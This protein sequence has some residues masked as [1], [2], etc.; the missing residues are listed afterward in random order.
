MMVRLIKLVAC[1]AL[2]VGAQAA[3]APQCQ[4]QSFGFSIASG[5]GKHH[6]HGHHHHCAP[7]TRWGFSYGYGPGWW[8]PPPIVYA[9]APIVQPVVQPIYVQPQTV[10]PAVPA[11]PYTVAPA[12]PAPVA[13]VPSTSANALPAS[14]SDDRVVIRNM[15][16]AELPVAFVVDGQE[17]ELNDGATRTFV[18]KTHRTVTYDRGGKFGSTQQ[19][20]TAG[21]YEFRVTSSGWDLVRRPESN[22]PGRT[23]IRG[24][25]L[26]GPSIS[27]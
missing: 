7:S 13:A 20:L 8:G 4:A 23:A 15:G 27:R 1:I 3:F 10:V 24:N 2:V 6:H 16:G 25:A 21:Q 22:S 9:P 14:T 5:G 26:P 12:Q 19:D 11:T 17:V 18:G